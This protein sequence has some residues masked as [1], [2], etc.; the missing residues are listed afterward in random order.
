MRAQMFANVSVLCVDGAVDVELKS[1]HNKN[2][3]TNETQRRR[4]SGNDTNDK[5]NG[6]TS[7]NMAV[8]MHDS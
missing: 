8:R 7:E 4:E 2:V 3:D 6:T 1:G 5:R